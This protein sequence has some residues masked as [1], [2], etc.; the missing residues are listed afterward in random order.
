MA[1]LA[2]HHYD[3]RVQSFII[4]FDFFCG[5]PGVVG[6]VSDNTYT[7]PWLLVSYF[8]SYTPDIVMALCWVLHIFPWIGFVDIRSTCLSC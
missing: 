6:G 1:A 3:E 4:S 8:A 2:V 5:S 7:V